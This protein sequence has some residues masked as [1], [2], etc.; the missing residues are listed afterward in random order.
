MTTPTLEEL[1]ADLEAVK[2]SVPTLEE[3]NFSFTLPCWN[4][5]VDR[6]STANAITMYVAPMP[7]RILSVA[8]SWEYWNLPAN[9]TAY[10]KFELNKGTGPAG[11]ATFATRTTQSTGANANGSIVA[12]KAWTFDAAAWGNADLNTGDL[13]RLT[14]SPV[15][16]V[17]DLDLPLTATVRYRAL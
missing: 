3:L 15:G 2:A 6:L 7:S 8:L 17:N 4:G 5:G 13:L 1:A 12:R 10:W 14:V 11:F 9:E 16:T